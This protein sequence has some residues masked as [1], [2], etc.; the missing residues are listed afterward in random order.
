[1]LIIIHFI[2]LCTNNGSHA[3]IMAVWMM[4]T[5]THDGR[6]KIMNGP[7]TLLHLHLY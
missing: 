1:M 4:D 3:L 2:Y 5:W 7:L 6:S